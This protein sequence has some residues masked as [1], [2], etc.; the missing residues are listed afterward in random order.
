MAAVAVVAAYANRGRLRLQIASVQASVP[1]KVSQ[2]E[3]PTRRQ[4]VPF[5]GDAPWA[6]SALP[7]CFFPASESTAASLSYVLAH[8]PRGAA[9]VRPPA[10]LTYHDCT[11]RVAG[12]EVFVDRGKDRLRIPPPVRLYAAGRSLAVL[13]VTDGHYE[14]RNYRVLP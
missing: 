11:I 2:T 5:T 4:A 8:L 1:P 3:P 9:M 14:L 13:R 7:E 10:R 12:D 6:L